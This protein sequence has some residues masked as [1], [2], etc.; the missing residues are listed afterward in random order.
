MNVDDIRCGQYPE[1]LDERGCGFWVA[2]AR[3]K[4]P[5]A[6]HRSM[7]FKPMLKELESRLSDARA[8]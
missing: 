1:E 6:I 7:F 5:Y 4:R 8:K 2:C 3:C